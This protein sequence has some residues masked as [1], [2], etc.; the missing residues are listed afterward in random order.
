MASSARPRPPPTI[1]PWIFIESLASNTRRYTA[2]PGS[3][4]Y[5]LPIASAARL[6]L[7]FDINKTVLM[8]DRA[9]GANSACVVNMLL[10]ECAW[11]RLEAGPQWVPVG[12]LATDR[13]GSLSMGFFCR[14]E[15][16]QQRLRGQHAA[17][18]VRVGPPRGRAAVGARWPLGRRQVGAPNFRVSIGMRQGISS[19]CAINRLLSNCARGRLD[20]GMPWVLLG[21][22]A[23]Q[24]GLQPKVVVGH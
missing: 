3:E 15:G 14:L 18:N 10:S 7:H 21:T 13:Q 8:A 4:L 20:T 19:V 1:D 9:Q 17:V 5:Q 23:S 6:V 2:G 24:A 11:G 22:L 16:R 12:R